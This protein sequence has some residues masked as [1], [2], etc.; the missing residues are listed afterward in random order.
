MERNYIKGEDCANL[1]SFSKMEHLHPSFLLLDIDWQKGNLAGAYILKAK[2]FAEPPFQSN[3]LRKI[4]GP[5]WV[6]FGLLW[7]ILG[8]FWAKLRKICR[9]FNF[10]AGSLGSQYSLLE[11]MG[12]WELSQVPRPS[13]ELRNLAI[14][15]WPRKM[16]EKSYIF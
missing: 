3:K 11:C 14:G 12:W 5:F 9:K 4:V 13:W 15:N 8:H 6:I 7:A 2:K 16:C 1:V 10:F